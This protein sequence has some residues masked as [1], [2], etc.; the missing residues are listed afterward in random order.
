MI[1]PT[2]GAASRAVFPATWA[3]GWADGG[4]DAGARGVGPGVGWPRHG[5]AACGD[6]RGA[7]D[8]GTDVAVAGPRAGGVAQ[9]N[10][11]VVG[12]VRAATGVAH[13]GTRKA[14][15]GMQFIWPIK[16]QYV[17]AWVDP[18]YRFVIVARDKRDYVWVMARTP[19]VSDADYKA[20]A[21][22]VVEMGYD[23][24]ALKRVPQ[25]WP[26]PRAD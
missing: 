5:G 7:W 10:G 8:G 18:E 17:I 12:A 15:G 4:R 23:S 3:C 9:G 14:V 26:E 20:L 1:T 2:A 25:Q 19:T 21:A 6:Q 22:R 24:Q 13:P 11:W 16:A